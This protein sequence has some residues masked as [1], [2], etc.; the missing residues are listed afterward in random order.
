MA[1]NGE[2]PMK[3]RSKQPLQN[4]VSTA[5]HHDQLADLTAI[6]EKR[7]KDSANAA[8]EDKLTG[9]ERAYFRGALDLAKLLWE[10]R[11]G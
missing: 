4:M 2:N 6:I 9:V 7:L 10:Q 11:R 5:F 1:I 3:A 8:R